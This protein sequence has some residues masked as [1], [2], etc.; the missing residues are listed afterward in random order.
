MEKLD[1]T[2][3]ALLIEDKGSGMSLMQDLNRRA[4]SPYCDPAEYG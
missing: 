2:D 4:Y 3:Y 1:P